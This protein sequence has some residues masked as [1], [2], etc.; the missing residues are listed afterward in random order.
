MTEVNVHEG[1]LKIEF[2]HPHGPTK[3]VSWP[4]F[5]DKCFVKHFIIACSRLSAGGSWAL[6]QFFK[7]GAGGLAGSQFLEGVAGKEERD[8]F[9]GGCNIYIKNNLKSQIFN[10]KKCLSANI[11]FSVTTKSLNLEIL[12]KNLVT[13]KR[14]DEIKDEEF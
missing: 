9:Q 12:T 4:S 3:I 10:Y 11:F 2:L 5:A 8:F 6:D 13:F 1:D 14:W 7:K